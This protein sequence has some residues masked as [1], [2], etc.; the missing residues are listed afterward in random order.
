MFKIEKSEE[1]ELLEDLEEY[2]NDN[3][4][5]PMTEWNDEG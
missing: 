4:L 2:E 1:D 5:D 3:D